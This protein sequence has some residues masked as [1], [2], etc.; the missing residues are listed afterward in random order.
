MHY[1][2]HTDSEYDYQLLTI[3]PTSICVTILSTICQYPQSPPSELSALTV[4]DIMQTIIDK[5]IVNDTSTN[6]KVFGVG[7]G[8]C[9]AVE[10]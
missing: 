5:F 10:N 4:N 8:G 2:L 6:I 7:G 3:K 9:N 1:L